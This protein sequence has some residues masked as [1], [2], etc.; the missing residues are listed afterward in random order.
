[1]SNEENYNEDEYSEDSK[2]DNSDEE[3]EYFSE[4]ENDKNN[5]LEETVIENE[6]EEDEETYNSEENEEEEKDE[7]NTCVYDKSEIYDDNNKNLNK[8]YYFGDNRIANPVLTSIEY[9]IILQTRALHVQKGAK[10]LISGCESLP[11]IEQVEQEIKYRK[12]PI[13][14]L[15][16]FIGSNRCEPW[17]LDELRNTK[18]FYNDIENNTNNQSSNDDIKARYYL[19]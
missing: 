2:S 5:V 12:T 8:V 6:N 10:L 11:V 17:S 19:N 18:I 9:Y 1:M 16:N 13:K 7:K 15:K 3:D 14:I 4:D